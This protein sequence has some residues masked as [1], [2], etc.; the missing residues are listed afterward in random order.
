MQGPAWRQQSKTQQTADK[1]GRNPR[2][3]QQ[4]DA[5]CIAAG[6]LPNVAQ[7]AC[8]SE[9]VFGFVAANIGVT[10]HL[11]SA[12]SFSRRGVVL[13]PL[14]GV[15]ARVCTEAAW[16]RAGVTPVQQKF[17]DFLQAWSPPD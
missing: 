5:L 7:K 4:L 8:N 14:K 17:I 1:A 13:R 3:T 10:V 15:T 2:I 12:G 11:E 16:V 9:A 6:F